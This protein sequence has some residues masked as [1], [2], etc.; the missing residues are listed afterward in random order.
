[1]AAK[2]DAGAPAG[3][4]PVQADGELG[5]EEALE[6]LETI[7]EDL[8]SGSLSLEESLARYEEGVKLSRGLT[9]TLDQAEKRIERLVEEQAG[10]TTQPMELDLKPAERPGAE[11]ELPF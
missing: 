2:R 3:S 11:D 6:R 9:K 8:E 5:F 7:V 1:M 4:P 10:P